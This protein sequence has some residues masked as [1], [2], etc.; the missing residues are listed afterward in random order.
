MRKTNVQSCQVRCLGP[1]V[2]VRF[3]ATDAYRTAMPHLSENLPD[4]LPPAAACRLC[5]AETD[6]RFSRL[7]LGKHTVG[8]YECRACKSLQ[9]ESP[10]WLHEA[11][12]SNLADIDTGA[13]QRNLNSLAATLAVT[14]LF[15][16]K[17]V[18]DFGGGDGLL[19][20]LLRD[21]GINC[22]VQDKY[23]RT[24]YAAGFTEP[25]F[26]QPQL[27]LSFEVF[28]HFPRPSIDLDKVFH[29]DADMLFISTV[30]YRGQGPEWPYLA[31]ESGQHVF[32][33]SADAMGVIAQRYGY[34]M[35]I[36]GEFVLFFRRPN[37]PTLRTYLL[38]FL[39]RGK[40]LRLLRIVVAALPKNGARSD[41]ERLTAGRR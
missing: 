28:E 4:S 21:H 7:V 11:Y 22:F 1:N 37:V 27:V 3:L 10:H 41:L 6:Y 29:I 23:A 36:F 19:C 34:A 20:R 24:T 9:T 15:R 2:Y 14:T 26:G 18:I 39:L 40:V 33:Y 25:S 17:D 12:G 30:L 31:T 32:F 16:L 35:C 8:Y 13:A 38:R 5:G